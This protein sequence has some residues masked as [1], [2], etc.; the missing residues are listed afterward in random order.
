MKMFGMFQHGRFVPADFL[1]WFRLTV[2]I[3]FEWPDPVYGV[4]MEFSRWVLVAF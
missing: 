4:P 2:P 1:D 3:T